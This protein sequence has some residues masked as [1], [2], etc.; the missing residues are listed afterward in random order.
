MEAEPPAIEVTEEVVLEEAAQ[1]A[2]EV[3]HEQL[4]GVNYIK[5]PVPRIKNKGAVAAVSLRQ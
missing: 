4:A 1:L 2:V 3:K 5:H